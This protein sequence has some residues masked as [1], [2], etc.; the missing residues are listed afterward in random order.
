M[1]AL[2]LLPPL[3]LRLSGKSLA[4]E[5][6]FFGWTPI[7]LACLPVCSFMRWAADGSARRT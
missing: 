4:S 6:K 3:L 7:C 2:D 1:W 5:G